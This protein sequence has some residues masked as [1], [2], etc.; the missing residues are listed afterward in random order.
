[1][2]FY[3]NIIFVFVFIVGCIKQEKSNSFIEFYEKSERSLKLLEGKWEG[4]FQV[5]DPKT[6]TVFYKNLT[7]KL[8]Y[9][10]T[11]EILDSSLVKEIVIVDTF[12]YK[13]IRIDFDNLNLDSL[14]LQSS[15]SILDS[16]YH[17]PVFIQ[18]AYDVTDS[19]LMLH[20]GEQKGLK[21]S[22]D[23]MQVISMPVI[24]FNSFEEVFRSEGVLLKCDLITQD[25]LKL[26]S[27]SDM[28]KMNIQ[29][30]KV[31]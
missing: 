27:L 14:K 8:E 13:P 12:S 30:N 1:M 4:K 26:S 11:G 25:S 22:E 18:P 7:E 28:L 5:I 9:Q 21:L 15:I 17:L 23:S 16:V 20:F 19:E 31:K 29:L 2:K 24:H 6:D 10:L 3:Y